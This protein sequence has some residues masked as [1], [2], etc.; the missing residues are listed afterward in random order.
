MNRDI[1]ERPQRPV[2]IGKVPRPL[3]FTKGRIQSVTAALE[4]FIAKEIGIAKGMR[5]QAA[6][7]Q[8]ALK[9]FLIA[10]TDDDPTF[11]RVLQDNGAT[12][13][14]GSWARHTK[15]WPLDDIDI[16]IPLD[17]LGLSYFEHGI[18]QPYNVVTDNVLNS[19]PILDV[20]RSRWME[21]NDVFSVKLIKEFEK[22]LKRRY[23]NT[24]VKDSE[25]A[26]N[27][28]MTYG[29][30][31]DED[32]LGFDVVPCF[33]LDPHNENEL[34]FY[35]IP[36]GQ[37]DWIRTNPKLD[38]IIA[39]ELHEKNDKTYRKVVKLVKYWNERRFGT[40]FSSYYVELAIMRYFRKQ[41]TADTYFKA[42]PRALMAGF[43]ALL[44]AATA[45]D[46]PSWLLKAPDVPRG[47]LSDDDI[48]KIKKAVAR[49]RLAFLF[50]QAGSTD[51]ALKQYAMV[52]GTLFPTN[53]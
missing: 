8:N 49:C 9:D 12:F 6:T 14:G 47:D 37:N 35:L 28:Q 39:Q 33:Y 19:N 27:V 36:N 3:L 34:P 11:P 41:N 25:Q 23:P 40:K 21:G 10:E 30:T 38:I 42:L 22:V 15:T 16:Y 53:E 13:L 2:T 44:E 52:F 18:M 4:S 45:G 17:G 24:K 7:S 31:E 1:F 20:G 50:E 26:V 29:E 5:E 46:Q 32:G 43:E 51:D 48:D